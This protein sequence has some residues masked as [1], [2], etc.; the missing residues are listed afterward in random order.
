MNSIHKQRILF[1]DKFNTFENRL[2][3]GKA[4]QTQVRNLQ[5]LVAAIPYTTKMLK[6]YESRDTPLNFCWHQFPFYWK[7]ANFAISRNTDI[8][9]ILVHDF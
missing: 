2:E 1:K 4:V 3:K 8:D 5:D 9:C 6:I 7:L